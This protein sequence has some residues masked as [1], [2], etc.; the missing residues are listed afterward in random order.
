VGGASE[1]A[2]DAAA[3]ASELGIVFG[4][5]EDASARADTEENDFGYDLGCGLEG[6][7]V[8]EPWPVLA[9]ASVA[10][11]PVSRSEL[12]QKAVSE[13]VHGIELHEIEPHARGA[14]F[15]D[16]TFELA[17]SESVSASV[18]ASVVGSVHASELVAVVGTAFAAS[19]SELSAFAEQESED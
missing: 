7:A 6:T 4:T 3:V 17:V 16:E 1:S 15:A 18:T 8:D 2:Y 10:P 13:L 19:T 12:A 14:A 11:G 9:L 5:L